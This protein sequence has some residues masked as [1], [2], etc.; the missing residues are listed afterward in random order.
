MRIADS[1]FRNDDEQAGMPV[2][3][4]CSLQPVQL[5]PAACAQHGRALSRSCRSSSKAAYRRRTSQCSWSQLGTHH[6][7]VIVTRAGCRI[8]AGMYF[9]EAF[10]SATRSRP[11]RCLTTSRSRACSWRSELQFVLPHSS[12]R[13]GRTS[14]RSQTSHGPADQQ[15]AA[16]GDI[17]PLHARPFPAVS[18]HRHVDFNESR[19]HLRPMDGTAFVG[20]AAFRHPGVSGS[21][22]ASSPGHFQAPVAGEIM[23]RP[24]FSLTR[25]RGSSS[26]RRT[27]SRSPVAGLHRRSGRR[28]AGTTVVL[29][30][31]E[32]EEVQRRGGRRSS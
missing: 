6:V 21:P 29:G 31:A 30:S 24:E 4:R 9:T 23:A 15:A 20:L 12:R 27:S 2:T 11:R 13:T 7:G 22:P 1:A 26:K 19:L 16:I 3:Q 32:Y 28:C 8:V 5:D 18:K 10:P 14:A 17:S 25:R